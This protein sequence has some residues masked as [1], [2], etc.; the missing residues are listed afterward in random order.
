MVLGER[1]ECITLFL[2]YLT[3]EPED[4]EDE[5]DNG[6]TPDEHTSYIAGVCLAVSVI[7]ISSLNI[8]LTNAWSYLIAR[9]AWAI[10]VTGLIGL[11]NL[12]PIMILMRQPRNKA[13]FP[14][15]VPCIPYLPLFSVFVNVLLIVKL[16]YWTYARFGV[17][18]CV[19][20]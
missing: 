14:F 1:W 7:L 12:V 6:V 19:G 20:R 16:N 3:D 9:E 17:W 8:I 11:L 10:F 5:E 18:M 4:A 15:M 2:Y 13:T